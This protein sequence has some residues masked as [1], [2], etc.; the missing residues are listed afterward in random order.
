VIITCILLG[1][2]SL[3]ILFNVNVDFSKAKY[4]KQRKRLTK[5]K[6]KKQVGENTTT[7]RY[8]ELGATPEL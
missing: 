5:M 3:S 8:T 1:Q 7:Y 6:T 4:G 2:I